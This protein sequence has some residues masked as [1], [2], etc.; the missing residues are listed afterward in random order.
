MRIRIGDRDRFVTVGNVGQ[1]VVRFR[2]ATHIAGEVLGR[3]RG[4]PLAELQ[5][6]TRC[7]VSGRKNAASCV[8]CLV[9]RIGRGSYGS[10]AFD[11]RRCRTVNSWAKLEPDSCAADYG[12][13]PARPGGR[14]RTGV[15]LQSSAAARISNGAV[16]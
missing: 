15:R 3:V 2:H 5:R 12:K 8:L 13:L 9:G 7:P 10:A 1:N 4:P 6:P 16:R 14:C 11:A